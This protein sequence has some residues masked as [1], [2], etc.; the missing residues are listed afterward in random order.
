MNEQSSLL[1]PEAEP[2]V[3]AETIKYYWDDFKTLKPGDF[4]AGVSFV[5]GVTEVV[6]HRDDPVRVAKGLAKIAFGV[7]YGS[8]ISHQ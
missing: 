5:A 2:N 8:T 1:L 7:G 3:I 6:R 4:L